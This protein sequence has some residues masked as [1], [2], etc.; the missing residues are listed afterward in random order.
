MTG[1]RR[2]VSCYGKLPFHPEYLRIGLESPASVWVARWIEQAHEAISAGQHGEPRASAVCF[3]V[4]PPGGAGVVAGVVRQSSD[5]QRRH[6]IVLFVADALARPAEHWHLLPLALAETWANLRELLARPFQAVSELSEAL[7]SLPGE[8]AVDAAAREYAEWLAA[9]APEGPWT[10]LT[11]ARGEDALNIAG[12]FLAVAEAQREARSHEEGVAVAVSLPPDDESARRRRS[13][14]WLELFAT[15]VGTAPLPTIAFR[16][17][18]DPWEQL[19]VLYR[20]AEGADL[21][22]MLAKLDTAPIDNLSEVWGEPTPPS[23]G[24]RRVVASEA[25]PLAE[26]RS[27]VQAAL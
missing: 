16:G 27:R 11:G 20:P 2:S 19:C 26:L 25:A 22:A 7:Q 8:L 24:L 5:G 3:A 9:A 14:L 23:D 1:S 4:A 15:A 12:N 21:A 17:E 18:A 13:S 10:A 6:P